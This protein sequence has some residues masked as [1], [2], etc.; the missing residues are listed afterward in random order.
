M[1]KPSEIQLTALI[2]ITPI[3]PYA[4]T[5]I[6]RSSRGWLVIPGSDGASPYRSNPAQTTFN[7]PPSTK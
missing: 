2:P 1:E 5:P 7:I 4:H 6:R 3:R